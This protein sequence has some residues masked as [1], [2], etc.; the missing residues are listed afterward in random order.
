[1][2]NNNVLIKGNKYGLT[3][4]LDKHVDFEIVKDQLKDKIVEASKFFEKAKLAITFENRELTNDEQRELI[5]VITNHSSIN[6]ICV[7]D[8]SEK[9]ELHFKK[10][11]DEKLQ[12]LSFNTGQ[13]YKG[14]LRS[15]Q[16]LEVENSIIVI[17][18]INPG[19]KIISKGNIIV[20][21]SLKGTVYA[22]AGG[23]ENAFVVALEMLPMQ[24]KI[25]DI[26]ARS[27]DNQS[28]APKTNK[29]PHIAFVDQG[30]IF[31]E[32]L[33]KNIINEINL[34]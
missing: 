18:D 7:M 27:P 8:N 31:I 2:T 22:G 4:I 10:K 16:L 23:N 26:I 28:M 21:G 11:L 34:M 17:G 1:M 12:E 9:E 24:I 25:G 30:N 29:D 15:G 5:E 13:F 3:I 19:A 14:T 33:S 6:V 20:I 32:P